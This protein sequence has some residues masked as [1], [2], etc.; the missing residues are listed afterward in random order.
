LGGSKKLEASAGL[1]F[2]GRLR[3]TTPPGRSPSSE[4]VLGLPLA[5]I[6]I[7]KLDH[8]GENAQ[9]MRCEKDALATILSM[10]IDMAV[11]PTAVRAASVRVASIMRD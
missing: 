9:Q 1:E 3:A 7:A 2:G 11:P 8:L 6:S 4:P 5:R 10:H